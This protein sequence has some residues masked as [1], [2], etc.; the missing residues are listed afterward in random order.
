M[1]KKSGEQGRGIRSKRTA[2]YHGRNHHSTSKP[3]PR[4]TGDP[5]GTHAGTHTCPQDREAEFELLSTILKA[6]ATQLDGVKADL[7]QTGSPAAHVTFRRHSG[8]GGGQLNGGA[9]TAPHS[10]GWC[11]SSLSLHVL[12][13]LNVLCS[14][15]MSVYVS[16]FLEPSSW[17]GSALIKMD[18]NCWI[19]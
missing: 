2:D 18:E 1:G 7:T 10:R 3:E 16:C 13:V 8:Q 15:D 19:P 11:K 6:R 4:S 14:S 17:E 12:S 9:N 5:V